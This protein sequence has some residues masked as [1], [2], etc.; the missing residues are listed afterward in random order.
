M[1][2][3]SFSVSKH[4][5]I[6]RPVATA[7]FL[8]LPVMAAINMLPL[9]SAKAN[10]QAEMAG[11]SAAV[12]GDITIAKATG[13]VGILV[14]SGMPVYLGDR[15]TTSA[16][17]GMQVLLLD[18]TVFTIGPNSD[19][20]I[21]EFVYDPATGEGRIVTDMAKGVMRFVTGKIPLNNPSSMD[22]NLPV[23]SI[24][25]RGTIGLIR[26][27]TAAEANQMVPGSFDTPDPDA[28]NQ[29]VF[30]AVNQGPGTQRNDTTS[31]PGAFAV[32]N[33]NGNSQNV[34]GENFGVFVSH[35]NVT[36][37]TRFPTNGAT[38]DFSTNLRQ[39]TS[40]GGNAG[41][42]EGSSSGSSGGS[43]EQQPTV[44][45]QQT[46]Q[47]QNQTGSNSAQAFRMAMVQLDSVNSGE[48]VTETTSILNNNTES[49]FTYD[50]LRQVTG[51][52]A[53]NSTTVSGSQLSYD[54]YAAVDYS[55]RQITLEFTNIND[56]S[57]D[58]Q[59]DILG[60]TG[61]S[62]FDYSGA[63]GPVSFDQSDFSIPS[64]NACE[65]MGCD[66]SATF[67][68]ATNVDFNLK[69]DAVPQGEGGSVTLTAEEP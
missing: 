62:N 58:P 23:G 50:A 59:N 5:S 66:A 26:S 16:D 36:P 8:C 41:D 53:S 3:T 48:N 45:E 15:I 19:I 38:F 49:G 33:N 37:P 44:T 47:A 43:G 24:G 4:K 17:S 67:T 69:V 46:G 11:V 13:E 7:A 10:V 20:A 60:E 55:S 68:D 64:G 39:T 35:N 40:G 9:Q 57:L 29:Q 56:G 6:L 63:N 65:T 34:T 52:S 30:M 31:R 27:M 32:F 18:E 54:F 42:D 51:G 61:I 2:K 25:I 1:N 14:E 28:A 22:V 21:D 12:T